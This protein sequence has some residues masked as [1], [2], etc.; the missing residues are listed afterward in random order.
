MS[1]CIYVQKTTN[2]LYYIEAKGDF[3]VFPRAV[4]IQIYDKT[5]CFI[6]D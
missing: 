4:V 3:N 6:L 5:L 1:L 2:P